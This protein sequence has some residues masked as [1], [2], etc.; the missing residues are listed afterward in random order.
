M[1]SSYNRRF[2]LLVVISALLSLTP[3]T[4][5][6]LNPGDGAFVTGDRKIDGI[7]DQMTLEEKIR[8]LF[9]GEQ[10]GISQ[11]PGDPRLGIP[12]MFPSDGP[13]GITAATDTAFPSGL[14]LAMSW[15]PSLFEAAGQVMGQEARAAGKTMVFAPALNILRDPL[16]GRFF[17]YLT[18]DP[19][20]DGKL[21]AS[22]V[23]G[24][25]DERVASCI[26]HFAANN[27]EWNRDW[28]MSNVD[29][30]ALKEIYLPGFKTAVQQGDAWAVMTAANGLNGQLACQNHWL[31]T[32]TLKDGWGFNGLVL[33]DYN[34]ARATEKAAL[35]GLDVSMPWSD[36]NT[37]SFGK[38]LLDDVIAGNIP[39]SLIDDKVRRILR[40]MQRVGLL[41]GVDPHTGGSANTPEHQAV[42]RR[43]AEE[44]LVLLKNDANTLPFHAES[45]SHVIVLGPNANLHLC[46]QGLGGSSGVRPP[47]EIT[48]FEGLVK[49]LGASKVEYL[50]IEE[51]GSFEAIDSRFLKTPDGKPGI[52]AEYF[53]DGNETAVLHRIERSI[54]FNWEMRSP[55]PAVVH[56]D[57][58]NAHFNALLTPTVS[59]YYTL[60]LSGQN[61]ATLW[62]NGQPFL[63][64]QAP[65]GFNSST[66]GIHLTA[67]TAY[68]LRID[69][70]AGV[71]D[72]ALH[73][74][75]S[76]PITAN[77]LD[78]EIHQAAP[79]LRKADAV[80]FV[81]GWNHGLDTEGL[82]RQ[83]MDFP[84]GQEQLIRRVAQLNPHTV[85]VLLHGSPF[86]VSG[87]IG[88]VPAVLDAWYPGMEGGTAI[89]EALVGDINPAGKLTF[90]WPKELKD[91]PTYFI[92]T[93]D[94]ENVNYKEGVFV[95]YR[96]FDT[97]NI[98]PQFPFGFGLSYSTFAYSGLT[99]IRAAHGFDVSVNVTNTSSRAGAEVV[100]LYVE[101]PKSVVA[102]P[103]HE[104]RGFQRLHLDPGQSA[105]ATFT[106]DE[107]SFRH[108]DMA[109]HGW[110]R[111]PGD[112]IIQV[113]DSSRDLPL[114]AHVTVSPISDRSEVSTT[115]GSAN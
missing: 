18:E 12:A 82:D 17:E 70:H 60:R 32:T 101:P 68:P 92:G 15:D 103:V 13:G 5:Q 93:A 65:D 56:T 67:G 113:G 31:L 62:L 10:P 34:R 43:A 91:S 100:Q 47:Y 105:Q 71:G 21:A 57:N 59:G 26:K 112:Y 108:W 77:Q 37:E 106:I 98:A 42:A 36:W 19:Y 2:Q 25:Q 50:P 110:E 75:W 55:D 95:G 78:E 41:D 35:A 97:R 4:A 52:D 9:G 40:V 20:L 33:T 27:R 48:P 58:F 53:N 49:R 94:K 23:V 16:D 89:A 29:E 85:V 54:D 79:K 102:R 109:T 63:T 80:I 38:P 39:L 73:L 6:E 107:T 115:A 45:L 83:N 1:Q 111:D 88:D 86:T 44:S 64:N 96:Y 114:Q 30:R 61:S 81:G 69:Y 46:D 76:L 8:M 66:A 87:W 84:K 24:I 72:A 104:L 22:M 90:S 28:Y 7:L 99:I 3:M 11:L 51:G 74:E 14:G